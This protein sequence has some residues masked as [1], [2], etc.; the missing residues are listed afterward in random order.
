MRLFEGRIFYFNQY[1]PLMAQTN[2]SAQWAE[3]LKPLTETWTLK[4]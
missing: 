4:H 1:T 2:L 3:K